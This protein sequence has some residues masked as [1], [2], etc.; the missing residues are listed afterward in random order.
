MSRWA[1]SGLAAIL[2]PGNR[3]RLLWAVRVRWLVVAGFFALAIVATRAGLFAS[4]R[5][6]LHA[7]I[8]GAVLN[9]FNHWCVRRGLLVG[10]VTA[11]AIPG[12]I[13]L[14]TYVTVHTGG[15]QSPFLMMYVVQVVTTAMLVDLV[16]ASFAAVAS[17]ACF[18]VAVALFP[19]AAA[20]PFSATAPSSAHPMV[21]ALFLFYCLALL[22]YVGGYISEQLRGSE[23][24]LA[25]RNRDLEATL[26]SLHRAHSELAG[27]LEQLRSAE[28]QLVQSEKLRALGQFVAGIAHELNNP[29]AFVAGNVE[30]LR[31]IATSMTG[32]LAAYERAPIEECQRRELGEQRRLMRMDEL[33]EDLPSVLDDCEEGARRAK[34]IVTALG[35]FARHD[36]ELRWERADLHEGIDRTLSLLRHRLGAE[37]TVERD[38]GE[39]PP[40]EC[41]RGQLDQVF[42]NLLANAVDAVCGRGKIRIRTA[43]EP[44]TPPLAVVSVADDGSGIPEELRSRIF[45]PFFTT[46]EPG[47]GT[48]LGLS[49][50]YDI[51]DRHGG[52]LGVDSAPGGGTVFTVRVP[53]FRVPASESLAVHA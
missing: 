3:P 40:V 47:K 23:R 52:T 51:V 22:A 11:L 31:R 42:L 13:L 4:I 24:D 53:L 46:K 33:L 41:L 18:V 2:A 29:I 17:V 26:A 14:I 15:V 38:Y 32:L 35:A 21:W 49:V 34:E 20:V 19:A 30:H 50:S 28:F 39:L 6:C 37:V 9:G 7:A 44:G 16:V 25:E 36:R 43:L 8:F 27:T 12:D 10:W 5:P 1:T 48:G 45:D